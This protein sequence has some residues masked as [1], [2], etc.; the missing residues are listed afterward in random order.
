M[1]VFGCT[2]SLDRLEGESRAT[3]DN[4]E[5]LR[6]R[7]AKMY[8]KMKA[9]IDIY[10][11]VRT[12][13]LEYEN[14]WQAKKHIHWQFAGILAIMFINAY[15]GTKY[16]DG[17]KNQNI[18]EIKGQHTSFNLVG[19]SVIEVQKIYHYKSQGC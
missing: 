18:G 11:H 13:S 5:F 4:G 14:F 12:G 9:G 2:R 6:P 1:I 17:Y 16:C 10:S 3:K 8:L 19:K 15:L 7:V